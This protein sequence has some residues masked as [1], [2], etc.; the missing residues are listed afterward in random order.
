MLGAFVRE[1]AERL[2]RIVGPCREI[3]QLCVAAAKKHEHCTY[4]AR[5]WWF[6]NFTL[7]MSHRDHEIVLEQ[8]DV[9]DTDLVDARSVLLKLSHA[10]VLIPH[11][12]KH[13]PH[14]ITVL[15]RDWL[16]DDWAYQFILQSV[17]APVRVLDDIVHALMR[18]GWK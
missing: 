11:M 7:N 17:R 14:G 4:C 9:C 12:L 13:A 15:L 6:A 1:S 2:P 16:Q 5:E 8:F 10:A 18:G 3:L